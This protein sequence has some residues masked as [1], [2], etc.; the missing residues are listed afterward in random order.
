MENNSTH[1]TALGNQ[2]A[3]ELFARVTHK[4]LSESP[5]RDFSDYEILLDGKTFP[6]TFKVVEVG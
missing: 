6:E 4:K 5:A 1:K 2:S 3:H